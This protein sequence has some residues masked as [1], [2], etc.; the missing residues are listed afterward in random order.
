MNIYQE[1]NDDADMQEMVGHEKQ[2][3]EHFSIFTTLIL[4]AFALCFAAAIKIKSLWRRN[5]RNF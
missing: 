5:A 2:P 1:Y 3:A 4:G